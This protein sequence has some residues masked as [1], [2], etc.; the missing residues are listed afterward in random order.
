MG[1]PWVTHRGLH[2]VTQ[3]TAHLPCLSLSSVSFCAMMAVTCCHFFC[4]PLRCR[5]S[6]LAPADRPDSLCWPSTAMEHSVLG[7]VL[8][9]TISTSRVGI[10]ADPAGVIPKWPMSREHLRQMILQV[11]VTTLGPWSVV[12]DKRMS[13]PADGFAIPF[14]LP[15]PASHA[16]VW[17]A[18]Y[19]VYT[20]VDE[21][22]FQCSQMT[23]NDTIT[24]K[25]TVDAVL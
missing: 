1:G 17:F 13:P 16:S 14:S 25:A 23:W 7:S 24:C 3:S 6:L 11:P 19:P 21:F 8:F 4:L 22:L 18:F 12:W 20:H 2:L 9:F 15:D 10:L 5:Q